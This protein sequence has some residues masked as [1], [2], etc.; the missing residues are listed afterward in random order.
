LDAIG[1]VPVQYVYTISTQ[2]PNEGKMLT[3]L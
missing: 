2:A 1:L 3:L